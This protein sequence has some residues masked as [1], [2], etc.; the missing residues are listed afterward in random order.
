M[1]AAFGEDQIIVYMTDRWSLYSKRDYRKVLKWCEGMR[2]GDVFG[3]TSYRS[4]TNK[5]YFI[6]RFF[7][8]RT[9]TEISSDHPVEKGGV[10]AIEG[11][12]ETIT[13]QL[14]VDDEEPKRV[15]VPRSLQVHQ[16][17]R[18]LGT[19]MGSVAVWHPIPP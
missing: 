4:A 7:D 5:L 12:E 3:P 8:A 11:K 14:K 17:G 13:I 2:I 15:R 6:E 19:Q 10:Y 16:L 18:S 1:E 9:M